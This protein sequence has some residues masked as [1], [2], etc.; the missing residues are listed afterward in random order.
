MS[1][2]PHHPHGPARTAQ[3]IFW[4]FCPLS[5]PSAQIGVKP[6]PTAPSISSSP[7]LATAG[8]HSSAAA[9]PATS[10][11]PSAHGRTPAC[12][13]A[14]CRSPPSNRSRRAHRRSRPQ[15]CPSHAS[16]TTAVASDT[17]TPRRPHRA[18]E[19]HGTMRT[20]P[21][22]PSPRPRTHPRRSRTAQSSSRGRC[23]H[24]AARSQSAPRTET[25]W[26]QSPPG[27]SPSADTPPRRPPSPLTSA[28]SPAVSCR[29]RRPHPCP[30]PC[31]TSRLGEKSPGSSRSAPLKPVLD[32][33]IR[34]GRQR[35]AS[36]AP[37]TL[38]PYQTAS[39][40]RSPKLM[41]RSPSGFKLSIQALGA[42]LMA[43]MLAVS[44]G[45]AQT[46]RKEGRDTNA[47]RKLR[48]ARQVKET[49][50]HRWEVG[51]GGGY[52]RFR[53]PPSDG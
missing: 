23:A 3:T 25:A 35:S 49:Y 17:Y 29:T 41:F 22:R 43:T 4:I 1:L 24:S 38:Q 30:L 21:C 27:A 15:R 26:P 51:G 52:L 18:P 10:A 39:P 12:P 53:R 20:P 44:S 34:S 19:S 32:V 42:V 40:R 6:L 28:P 48:A 31:V 9:S 46:T 13:L 7:G 2:L 47:N 5:V 8:P 16:S 45:R 33:L 14:G 37:A 36:I 11:Y 50:T